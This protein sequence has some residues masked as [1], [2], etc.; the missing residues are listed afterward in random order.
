VREQ[1]ESAYPIVDA[2]IPLERFVSSLSR[3]APA[4]L[5]RDGDR[6]CGIITRYDVL[7][8]AQGLR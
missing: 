6:F 4:V 5:V 8:H 1:M 3:E 7:H 2:D